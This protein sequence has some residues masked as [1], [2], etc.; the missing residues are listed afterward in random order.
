MDELSFSTAGVNDGAKT[1]APSTVV[2]Q[3][4]GGG[5]SCQS[6]S[7]PPIAPTTPPAASQEPYEWIMGP[8]IDMLFVC[9]GFFWIIV[10]ALYLT[11]FDVNLYGSPTA[12]SLAT[13]SIIGLQLL[14]DAHQPATLFRVYGSKTTRDKL[15]VPV[16][17]IGVFALAVGLCAFFV[18]SSTMLLL[19]IILAWGI[20]HQLAQSYGIALV[21]CYKRKYYLTKNEKQVMFLMVQSA[22]V[23]MIVRMF[24]VKE[25]A[26]FRLSNSIDVPFWNFLPSWTTT[27]AGCVLGALVLLFA[28]VVA[29]KYVR[30][31]QMFPLPGL[32]TLMSLIALG[33]CAGDKFLIIWYLFSTWWFHSSQY[34]VITSAFYLKEKG[35]PENMAFSEIGKLLWSPTFIKYYLLVFGT[36]FTVFYLIP[37]WLVSNGVEKAVAIGAVYI[38]FNLHHYITDALIWKLR[39]PSIQKLLIA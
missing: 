21:Y 39:D 4:P 20:Q 33:L 29:R 18:S 7:T 36:G 30:D 31:K 25:F 15:G 35:L 2:A 34:L 24:S 19:K 26:Q 6:P 13:V 16:T 11:N 12:F 32:C 27:V 22:I 5:S 38:A 1:P 28:G 3:Q 10:A 17:L 8:T 9:G 23:F 14:G 37:C